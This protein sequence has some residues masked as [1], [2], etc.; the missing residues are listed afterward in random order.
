MHTLLEQINSAGQTFI[1][2]AFPMLVQS[3]VL[4]LVLLFI[5]LLLRKRVRAVFRYGIWM[6]VLV[7]LLLPTSLSWPL[8]VGHFF[9]DKLAYVDVT[10]T[11]KVAEPEILT[12]AEVIVPKN[13][14]LPNIQTNAQKPAISTMPANTEQLS[15][16]MVPASSEPPVVSVTPVSWQGIVFLVWLS[17][18]AAMGLLL[19]Q[20]VI[21][22]RRLVA[23]AKEANDLMNDS[24]EYCRTRMGVRRK[25]G[26]KVSAN[27]TSPAVCGLF[28]R[29]I[30]VPQNLAPSLGANSLRTV[31]LHE[32][33][34]IKRGD[35]WVNLVQTILQVIYF[36]NP[37]LWLANAI[38]RRI[39]E[40]A[41]D[42][43][44]QVA[45]GEKA[46][47]YPET[48]VNIAKLAFGRPALSLRLIGVV[49]SKSALS[50]RIK[51]ILN[52]P[53]PK[54]AKLGI[55]GLFVVIIIG[56]ILLPMASSMQGPP[57]LVIKGVVKD[58][59]TNEP[60][61]GARVFDD[62]YG[63]EP[64]WEQ[65]RPD[66]RSKWGAIT[67][68]AGQYSFLTWPEHHSIKVEA[69]GYTPQRRS[70]YSGHL[71]F[72]KKDEEIFDFTLE[73]E[74]ASD[75]SEFKKTLPNGVT[76]EL[77]GVCEHPSEGKQWWRPDGSRLLNRPYD[78]VGGHVYPNA[79]EQACEFAVRVTSPNSKDWGYS[80]QIEPGGSS[81]SGSWPVKNGKKQ[82]DLR[83]IA[84]SMPSK[85]EVAKVSFAVASGPWHTLDNRA[86]D[87]KGVASSSGEGGGIIWLSPNCNEN[88]TVLSVC[89]T[90]KE[91]QVRIVAIGKNGNL[92]TGDYT[93]GAVGEMATITATFDLLLSNIEE[94]QFQTRPYRM[95]RF[96]DVS[97]I[98]GNITDVKMTVSRPDTQAK[99][100][101]KTE[102]QSEIEGTSIS[103]SRGK[104]SVVKGEG[105]PDVTIRRK[106]PPEGTAYFKKFDQVYLLEIVSKSYGQDIRESVG[107]KSSGGGSGPKFVQKHIGFGIPFT[108]KGIKG[109]SKLKEFRKQ[110]WDTIK[111]DIKSTLGVVAGGGGT[112]DLQHLVYSTDKVVGSINIFFSETNEDIL[113]LKFTIHEVVMIEDKTD[114]Q[115]EYETAKGGKTDTGTGQAEAIEKVSSFIA[116]DLSASVQDVKFFSNSIFGTYQVLIRF[117]IAPEDLK[118]LMKNSDKLPNF[119]DL[120]KNPK[121]H[122][123]M[124]ETH[125]VLKID[126]WKPGELESPICAGWQKRKRAMGD[127]RVWFYSLLKICCSREDNNLIRVYI[128]F[129]SEPDDMPFS[130]PDMERKIEEPK[131]W[132]QELAGDVFAAIIANDNN[133][134]EA[135]NIDSGLLSALG[136]YR[137]EYDFSGLNRMV[138]YQKADRCFVIVS[139]IRHKEVKYP[140]QEIRIGFKLKQGI[141]VASLLENGNMGA[142]DDI[143]KREGFEEF[144]RTDL[145]RKITDKTPINPANNSAV[146]VENKIEQSSSVGKKVT[147]ID[148]PFTFTIYT[149]TPDDKPQP[150]VTIR[151]VHPRPERA[152]PIVDMIAESDENGVATFIITKADLRTDWIYWFSLEDNDYIGTPEVG[153]TPDEENWTFKVL[154]AEEIELQVTADKEAVPGA[155]IYLYV[156]HNK[157]KGKD[158]D[159]KI[160]HAHASTRSDSA[161]QV[162]IK[163]VKDKI[164][165][166]VAAKGYASTTIRDVELSSEK[167]YL[168]ELT[169][170]RAITGRVTDS[171]NNPL[172][173]VAI[174]AKKKEIFYYDEEFILKSSTDENGKF[175]LKN[176]SSGQWEIS[177]RSEDPTM[178]YFIA[179]VT[180]KVRS[181]WPVR[182]I[183]MVAREGFRLKGRYVTDY[184]INIKDDGGLPWIDGFVSKPSRA[185]MQLRTKEDGT[186]DIWG[187]PCEGEGSIRFVG[188]GGYHNFIKMPKEYSYF[189]IFGARLNFKNVPPGTYEN[190]EVHYL[191]EGK[192]S[193]TVVDADGKPWPG[194]EV[195]AS[196]KGADKTDEQGKYS[197]WVPPGD[198]VWL[199]VQYPKRAPIFTTDMFSVKEGQAI[200]KNFV[201][202]QKL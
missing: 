90:Y 58:A 39:R 135:L 66:Q 163:F 148:L 107:R 137:G 15:K 57:K 112:S 164:D 202:K 62:K 170:G 142:K 159:P 100:P 172:K 111:K 161:G 118:N 76:V 105:G 46:G 8:S 7:K 21:F 143:L 154:P 133:S 40:Q 69:P 82:E 85:H 96:E 73:P 138:H 33:A 194:L 165:I 29:V 125:K 176:A 25:V 26:L 99:F 104:V 41:V 64:V 56:A 51:H 94:F 61:A 72:N 101:D 14:D 86:A 123:A 97:L 155:K 146:Q 122:A 50:A 81:T 38:I 139:P 179:P 106:L 37:L 113:Q 30:L 78:K 17:A 182:T 98:P 147:D 124:V 45:M 75:S 10:K 68:E 102:M 92:H 132:S 177:A 70:L 47:Q 16:Q 171:K 88:E 13:A 151:C 32:L 128:D 63:P 110:L 181:W 153:I 18:V 189:K 80:W 131:V 190:I 156:D 126:W 134:F 95:V 12:T 3:S 54:R 184:K 201:V 173:G 192:I 59:T 195:V 48:L 19:L 65:I 191:L 27:A 160:F 67:N 200:E 127:P 174:T 11:T 180:M 91:P 183:K 52:R 108:Y 166:A 23:Q 136:G 71:V 198:N 120:H 114:V 185:W 93:C 89:H 6:L 187:F 4:I 140:D 167:P 79:N 188:V 2:F 119:P 193:G 36:Y 115:V 129:F 199:K 178:P 44:V 60:I 1:T 157:G 152:E 74:K 55:I 121:I 24:L 168:I 5:D 162:R 109:F 20:R 34:H 22:V 197:I 116:C 84:I 117:D 31:L 77:V 158:W 144:S 53:M 87:G 150:G 196:P 42:E 186:F 103:T 35:L 83:Y 169:K 149:L 28:R 145:T 175:T 9:G 141:W 130:N 49:E 43:T